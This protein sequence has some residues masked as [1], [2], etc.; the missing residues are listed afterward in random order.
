[1]TRDI[2][3]IGGSAGGIETALRLLKAIPADLPAAVF[4]VIHTSPDGGGELPALFDRA[5][6]LACSP[7]T[8][9]EGIKVGRVYVAPPDH[10]LLLRSGR[11]SIPHGPKE[12]R[13][14]PAI[15]PLFRSAAIAYG[16]R[17]IGVVL[18]GTLD[19]GSAGL[20]LI[21]KMGGRVIVQHPD[22]ALFSG[23][24][25]NAMEAVRVDFAVPLA[26]M[27]PLLSD[28]SREEVES[29]MEPSDADREEMGIAD[30]K[31]LS[32]E[33]MRKVA[34]P[35][36]FTCPDCGGNLFEYTHDGILRYRCSIG[37]AMSGHSLL[38]SHSERVEDALATSLRLM[39]E[40][41]R[42]YRKMSVDFDRRNLHRSASGM[43]EKA[44]NLEKHAQV[45]Q[46]L[47]A[48]LEAGGA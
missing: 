38:A 26:E 5:G 30:N 15:D 34:V 25:R 13:H 11:I 1:V 22:D 39:I 7:V 37:H 29:R 48:A 9:G 6:P 36:V 12:N 42:L 21:K 8:E 35:S 18:S 47:L 2:I 43:N 10:H 32:E 16:P 33:T 44:E 23:M 41:Q 27:A 14:R 3:V 4:V 45:I 19:D 28:L 17:V 31:L 40:N 24:P 20:R 46:G